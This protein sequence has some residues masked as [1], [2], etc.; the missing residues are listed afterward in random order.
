MLGKHTHSIRYVGPHPE[1]NEIQGAYSV[2]MPMLALLAKWLSR[3]LFHPGAQKEAKNESKQ[4][5]H[6]QQG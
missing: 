5:P 2:T 3:V 4:W 6:L 1:K